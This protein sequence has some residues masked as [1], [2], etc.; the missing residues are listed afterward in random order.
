MGLGQGKDD[1]EGG[2]RGVLRRRLDHPRPCEVFEGRTPPRQ[3]REESGDV[4]KGVHG[5]KRAARLQDWPEVLR[6]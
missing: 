1:L 4:G 6:R 2:G 3:R 5:W